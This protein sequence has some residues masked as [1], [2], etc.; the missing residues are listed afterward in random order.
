MEGVSGVTRW[1]DVVTRGQDYQRARSWMTADVN[2]AVAGARAAGA[3]EFVV[4]E[5][6]GVEMLC[7]LVLDEIDPEVDVVRGQPRGGATTMAALDDSFDAM[8]LVGH[9][10]AA[11]DYPGVCAH[12]I[13]YGSYQDVRL[14]GRSVSEGEIFAL[15]AAQRAVPTALITGDDVVAGIMQKLCPG[16]ET[17]PVKRALSREAA[18][19]IPPVRAQRL[20]HAAA[21]R[22]VERVR[23]GTIDAP[24]A[25]PPSRP[26]T[27]R[28][29]VIGSP[30]S[31]LPTTESSRSPSTTWRWGSAWL[32]SC[33]SWRPIRPR[34]ETTEASFGRVASNA[35]RPADGRSRSRPNA[36]RPRGGAARIRACGGSPRCAG[37]RRRCR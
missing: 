1:A 3:T 24:E 22:A 34:S 31:R 37:W 36:A 2:A 11:G 19:I 7:N 8:F 30:S 6:H 17:A 15:A 21:T 10:A 5:N 12:T 4:E 20:I 35:A 16:I 18:V 25:H 32:R 28:S 33:S 13:S 29:S 9:H 26:S 23:S 27:K 14:D